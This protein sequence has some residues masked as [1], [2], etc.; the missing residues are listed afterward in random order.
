MERL[1]DDTHSKAI[2]KEL[3]HS[4]GSLSL[5]LLSADMIVYNA[6]EAASTGMIV[7]ASTG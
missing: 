4:S 2:L 7:E 3:C 6:G 5:V 1:T